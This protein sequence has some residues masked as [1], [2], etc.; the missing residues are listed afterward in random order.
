M[1]I[2]RATPTVG[3]NETVG[4]GGAHARGRWA[5][6]FKRTSL[7]YPYTYEAASPRCAPP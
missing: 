6:A 1:K 3:E 4:G 5:R 2:A 7:Y